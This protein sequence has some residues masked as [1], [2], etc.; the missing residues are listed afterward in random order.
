MSDK[1][2]IL[3]DAEVDFLLSSSQSDASQ[4]AGSADTSGQTVTMRG[5]LEQINLTDIFQTLAMSK[6][7][8]VLHVRNPLEERQVYCSNGSVRIKVPPRLSLRRLGQRLVQAGLLAPEN[9]R[10]ALVAQRKEQMPLGELLVRDGYVTQEEVEEVASM[11]VAEDLF[12]LF[13]WRHGTFEFYKG[14][15]SQDQHEQFKSCPEFDVS[16]LLLEVARRADEWSEILDTIG[17]LEE[18]PCRVAFPSEDQQQSEAHLALL[19]SANG[20]STYRALAEQTTLGLFEVARAARDLVRA[21]L[22]ANVDDLTLANVAA[23]L[24]TDGEGKRAL[25]LL[26]TLR[27]RPGDRSREVVES[28][29]QA[30]AQAG[31]R[32]LAGL[33]LLEAAQMEGDPEAALDLARRARELAPRDPETN[34]FLRTTLLAHATPDSPELEQCTID[35]L[36]AL[37]DADLN[38]TALE[39]IEDARA[40]GSIRP[41]ILVREVRARQRLRDAPG[42]AKAMEE[43]AAIYEQ[44]GDR[45]RLVETLDAIVRLDRSRTDLAKKVWRLRQ[46]RLGRIIRLS[47]A[48]ICVGLLGCMGLVWWEQDAFDKAVAQADGEISEMLAAGNRVGARERLA[49]WVERLGDC[50]NTEDFRRRVDFADASE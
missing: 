19:Q 32:K 48:L 39:V 5:D 16:S 28:M 44:A 47:A 13:T 14:E 15:I 29:T 1:G 24:A 21:G 27:A 41:Q 25:L 26:Q 38:T 11:Q 6:M 20:Q 3:D 8:G 18:V 9:L 34:A 2:K 36:D 42:A 22:I 50:D 40:T 46:T 49:H 43:L 7:E 45:Q 17:C 35:L 4:Q 30:L 31:E 37:I 33:V 23:T 12:S 10:T